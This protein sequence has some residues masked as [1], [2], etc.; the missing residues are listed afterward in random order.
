MARKKRIKVKADTTFKYIQLL[1]GVFK[2]TD[3][4]IRVLADFI[5]LYKKLQDAGID[6]NPF[7]TENK[8]KVADK[9][10]RDDFNTLNHYIQNLRKKKAISK[11]NRGYEI[12][13]FLIPKDDEQGI[14][15]IF[16]Q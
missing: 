2:L 14:T 6:T 15:F 10:G 11:T 4:E 3:M 5:D 1:N 9:Q 8:K 7:S 13:P 16:K 12:H